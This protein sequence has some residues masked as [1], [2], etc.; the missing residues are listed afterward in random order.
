MRTGKTATAPSLAA[1]VVVAVVASACSSVRSRDADVESAARAPLEP[2]APPSGAA[3]PAAAVGGPMD[4]ATLARQTGLTVE[5]KGNSVLLSGATLARF[6][7]NSDRMCIDG[8][9]QSM[10]EPARRGEIGFVIPAKGVDAVKGAVLAARSRPAE[11]VPVG[12]SK[13]STP[14]SMPASAGLDVPVPK[15]AAM[16]TSGGDPAWAAIVGAERQWKWIVVHHSD[17]EAGCCAKYD[18]I[19]RDKGWD[20]C[21][22]DF[23]IGNGT[24]SGDGQ[25]EVGPRWV[26][27]QTG[28]HAK[29]PDN[30]YN[31][32]GVGIVLV[33]DFERGGGPTPRQ[34]AALV[35]LTK[36]LMAR[37][38]ITS[39]R[40]LRHS[41]CKS[42]ACPGVNFPW[43]KYIADVSR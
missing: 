43:A 25:V 22:Y 35:R 5:D 8:K 32:Y 41:D 17:D 14:K 36:W 38:H 2:V 33:G 15:A 27:Q 37:Y 6:F 20:S 23:V 10:G 16:K 21:G 3:A 19:H 12:F 24:Q 40:V 30:R 4:A 1:L 11:F 29:T 28:A 13:P 39:D 34:Y 18:R 7:P 26:M 42:T 9:F 31:D